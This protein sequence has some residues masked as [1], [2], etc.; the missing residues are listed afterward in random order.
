MREKE[1]VSGKVPI[2]IAHETGGEQQHRRKRQKNTSQPRDWLHFRFASSREPPYK[3]ERSR[4][5]K[6]Q[7]FVRAAVG[8]NRDAEPQQNRIS[9]L[10]AFDYS[11]AR[12]QYKRAGDL[13]GGAP[14]PA[15]HAL[16]DHAQTHRGP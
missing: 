1:R 6:Q 7:A 16:A 4:D 12:P 14:P 13:G 11:R 2:V 10:R 15:V 3:P 5:A 9:R 8:Q